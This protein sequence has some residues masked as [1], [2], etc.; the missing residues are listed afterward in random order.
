MS[1]RG[2]EIGRKNRTL[3]DSVTSTVGCAVLLSVD[4]RQ[5][6]TDEKEA[7]DRETSDRIQWWTLGSKGVTE[8]GASQMAF[9]SFLFLMHSI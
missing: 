7:A 2:D 4:T 9:Q 1:K 8:G 5:G 6:F 3:N